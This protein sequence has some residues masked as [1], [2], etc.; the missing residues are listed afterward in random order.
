MLKRVVVFDLATLLQS[1]GRGVGEPA[2]AL[3][4]A[5]LSLAIV[6]CPEALIASPHAPEPRGA[7]PCPGAFAWTPPLAP[8]PLV[9]VPEGC[10]V[11]PLTRTW[12]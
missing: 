12:T 8:V 10:R 9:A 6:L 4:H 7:W 2:A 11:L 1:E 5:G 3:G